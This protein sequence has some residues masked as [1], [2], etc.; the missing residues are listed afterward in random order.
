MGN[1]GKYLFIYGCL[2]PRDLRLNLLAVRLRTNDPRTPKRGAPPLVNDC[3]TPH[4]TRQ[5]GA[6]LHPVLEN[7]DWNR[8]DHAVFVFFED[9]DRAP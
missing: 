1:L 5:L 4:I 3:K 8:E 7:V 6:A 9:V 2:Y